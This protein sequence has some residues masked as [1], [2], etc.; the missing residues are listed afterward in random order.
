M[1]PLL[2]LI[3]ILAGCREALV[4]EDIKLNKIDDLDGNFVRR[5]NKTASDGVITPDEFRGAEQFA[6]QTMGKGD[7]TFVDNLKQLTEFPM[8]NV[9]DI[10]QQQGQLDALKKSAA[11]FGLNIYNL[12][13]VLSNSANDTRIIETG[14]NIPGYVTGKIEVRKQW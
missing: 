4:K 13:I 9:Q 1:W 8:E 3:P 2:I 6:Q 5:W 10:L 12:K 11:K 14:A 7:D